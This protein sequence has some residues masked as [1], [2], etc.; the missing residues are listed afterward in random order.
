MD[1]NPS[2]N[3]AEALPEQ[4]CSAFRRLRADPGG[5][6]APGGAGGGRGIQW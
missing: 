6:R 3:F 4:Q 2:W 1:F 5:A